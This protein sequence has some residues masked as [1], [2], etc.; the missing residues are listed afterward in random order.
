MRRLRLDA[1][2]V[3]HFEERNAVKS[4]VRVPFLNEGPAAS[5]F[6]AS[7][8]ETVDE[9]VRIDDKHYRLS[10]ASYSAS[11]SAISTSAPPR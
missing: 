7:A 8:I 4:G 2:G 11:R 6:I 1:K 10:I 5:M 9:D 3:D